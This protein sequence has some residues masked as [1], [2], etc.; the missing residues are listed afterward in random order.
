MIIIKN[1]LFISLKTLLGIL[2][3]VYMSG[4]SQTQFLEGKNTDAERK[5]NY[6]HF[7]DIT[8][9]DDIIS[10]SVGR[11]LSNLSFK[12]YLT[13]SHYDKNLNLQKE[14]EITKEIDGEVINFNILNDTINIITKDNR[15]RSGE[16]FSLNRYSCSVSN[17]ELQKSILFYTDKGTGRFISNF[18]EHNGFFAIV[19]SEENNKTLQNRT[20]IFN[21]N[22]DLVSEIEVFEQGYLIDL[23]FDENNFV[24]YLNRTFLEDQETYSF[25]MNKVSNNFQEQINLDTKNRSLRDLKMFSESGGIYFVGYISELNKPEVLTGFF[26]GNLSFSEF[27]QSF[28]YIIP[29]TDEYNQAIENS[30]GKKRFKQNIKL[31]TSSFIKLDDSFIIVSESDFSDQ[32]SS[33]QTASNFNIHSHVFANILVAKIT[34]SGELSTFK[35]INRRIS[36]GL[37]TYLPAVS[38]TLSMFKEGKLHI[39]FNAS[40]R[41]FEG[42]KVFLSN[43][44]EVRTNEFIYDSNLEF[45][46]VKHKF[47]SFRPYNFTVLKNNYIIVMSNPIEKKGLVKITP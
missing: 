16:K 47:V 18:S 6:L 41:E 37:S 8:D 44:D 31:Q 40:S 25:N 7:T 20:L 5:I 24:Y 23:V 28:S 33:N 4:N 32:L 29:F 26:L 15:K 12:E 14:V 21:S 46:Y 22:F 27:K 11:K 43:N 34:R 45:S 36:N 1:N 10:L 30:P 2:Y 35:S 38:P 19:F 42:E 3:F 13:L 39:I 17:F 9:S